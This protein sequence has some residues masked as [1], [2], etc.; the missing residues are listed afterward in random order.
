MRLITVSD[1][2]PNTS[3]EVLSVAVQAAPDGLDCTSALRAI[4]LFGRNLAPA[5]AGD[6]AEYSPDCGVTWLPVTAADGS[7]F[8]ASMC[9]KR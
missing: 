8:Q 4:R 3:R 7:R 2:L 9:I 1:L 5:D 6:G